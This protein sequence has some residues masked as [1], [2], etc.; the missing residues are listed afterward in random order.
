MSARAKTDLA[1]GFIRDNFEPSD[2]LALVLINKRM[3]T[4]IQRLASAERL[5]GKEVLAWLS[6]HNEQ[7]FDIYICMNALKPGASRRTKAD[8]A[9]IR[10]VYLDFDHDGTAAV[11]KLLKRTDVPKPNHLISTSPEK[12][13]VTWK[14]DGFDR[15]H[16]EELQRAMARD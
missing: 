16:A 3:N 5:A 4:V 2:R 10:H 15:A 14:V 1:S 12:W 8:V 7:R 6:R 13:Q 11:E 9:A